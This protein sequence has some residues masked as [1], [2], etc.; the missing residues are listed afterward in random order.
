MKLLRFCLVAIA[1]T[2]LL[3]VVTGCASPG[4]AATAR[5]IISSG[6]NSVEIT[7]PK[8]TAVKRLRW[9]PGTGFFEMED[10][11]SAANAGVIAAESARAQ[12]QA[13]TFES[14][15]LNPS[16][17]T[18]TNSSVTWTTGAT[19]SSFAGLT[20]RWSYVGTEWGQ[21]SPNY[22]TAGGVA[23]FSFGH[24]TYKSY[25]MELA[26]GSGYVQRVLFPG[27]WDRPLALVAAWGYGAF[28]GN[29]YW[30]G[31]AADETVGDFIRSSVVQASG[32]GAP[33]V[34]FTRHWIAGDLTLPCDPITA[35]PVGSTSA[36]TLRVI[37]P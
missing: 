3:A 12:A 8:D 6:T 23:T 25:H 24:V 30:A 28:G 11:A 7:Q 35:R 37:A 32:G 29:P 20:N 15:W 9:A 13:A 21:A 33:T 22:I 16:T 5:I 36:S 27:W 10:Y 34:L 26:D 1:I 19:A 2:V 18:A 31:T 17:I 14:A 4:K